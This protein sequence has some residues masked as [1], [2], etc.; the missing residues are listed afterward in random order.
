VAG[1]ATP[2]PMGER[3]PALFLE[4][5]LAQRMVAAFDEVLAPV[6][7]CLDNLDA[8][9]DPQLAP[10]DFLQ[11]LGSWVGLAL[12]E[13]WPVERRRAFV[14]EACRLYRVRGTPRGLAAHLEVVTGG[15]VEVV[16]TGATAYALVPD[17]GLP[18]QPGFELTVRVRVPEQGAMDVP[19]L[20]ALIA[21]AK[22]AHVVHRLE[23]L[24]PEPPAS[25]GPP[26]PPAP[27]PG[28][29]EVPPAAGAERSPREGRE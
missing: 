8:Y 15:E 4:D 20:D 1:L 23:V 21:A 19:R 22:P 29:P 6:F 17:A 11:W 14:A 3:L 7:S 16:D 5:S 2:H 28:P 26:A 25:P 10:E 27:E 12:E 13:S 24:G 18:G 9:L